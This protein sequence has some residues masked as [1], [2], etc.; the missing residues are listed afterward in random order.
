MISSDYEKHPLVY[1]NGVLGLAGYECAAEELFCL[2]ANGD[3]N[4][5]LHGIAENSL[6]VVD[7]KLPYEEDKLS[8][9]Q[10]NVLVNGAYQPKLSLARLGD[11]PYMGR[12]I[13]AISQFA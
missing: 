2:H 12:V 10:T 9:F 11:C 6:L 8:V 3:N 1:R 7:P 4:F 5:L 13:M